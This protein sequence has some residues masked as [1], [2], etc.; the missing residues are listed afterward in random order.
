MES[1]HMISEGKGIEEGLTR[2][3][4]SIVIGCY[5]KKNTVEIR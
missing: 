4:I 3:I 1:V 5:V 2:L